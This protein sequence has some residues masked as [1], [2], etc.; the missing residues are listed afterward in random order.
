MVLR[1][2]LVR[3]QVVLPAEFFET[4]SRPA[5][6]VWPLAPAEMI[7]SDCLTRLGWNR[8]WFIRRKRPGRNHHWILSPSTVPLAPG[9]AGERCNY[10]HC[11]TETISSV[12]RNREP[13]L[14]KPRTRSPQ[15]SAVSRQSRGLRGHDPLG[16][17]SWV[18]FR[19]MNPKTLT[20]H[21]LTGNP[22]K[23]AFHNLLL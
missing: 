6:S 18:R 4:I 20:S 7:A 11:H 13:L 8:K 23:E 21:F 9:S 12:R 14:T 5:F 3:V 2:T 16:Y 17:I 19:R 15:Q 10:D 22:K 1:E